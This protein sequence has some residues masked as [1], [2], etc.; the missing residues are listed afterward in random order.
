M[1]FVS[2]QGRNWKVSKIKECILIVK[3]CEKNWENFETLRFFSKI[4]DFFAENF[5]LFADSVYDSV[6]DFP[7]QN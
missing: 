7:S 1:D 5:R 6:Y 2:V 4:S 3:C